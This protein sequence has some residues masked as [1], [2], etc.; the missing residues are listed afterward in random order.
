MALGFLIIP[1]F[2]LTFSVNIH[3]MSSVS[4]YPCYVNQNGNIPSDVILYVDQ[5]YGSSYFVYIGS[6]VDTG[7]YG[8]GVYPF[9]AFPKNSSGSLYA[10]IN[11][12]NTFSL[13]GYNIGYYDAKV[14]SIQK[15]YDGS[16]TAYLIQG[17]Y[18][19][20][21]YQNR[22]S[23]M[24]NSSVDYYTN[25]DLMYNNDHSQ[26]V[27]STGTPPLVLPDGD[28]PTSFDDTGLNLDS[29]LN[30]NNVPSTPSGFSYTA[31]T[32]PTWDS[33]QPVQSVWDYI[34]YGFSCLI[35]LLQGVIN[36]ISNW[37]A[38]IGNILSYVVQKILNFLKAIVQW[39]Y[40][41]FLAWLTPYLKLLVFISKILF[42]EE[43]QTNLFQLISD[44]NDDVSTWFGS[45]WSSS[46]LSSYFTNLVNSYSTIQGYFEDLQSFFSKVALFYTTLVALGSTNG[47][48]ALSTLV[49]NLF[50]PNV[51][52]VALL[53]Y[54]NDA[55]DIISTTTDVITTVPGLFNTLLSLTPTPTFHIP[56][57]VYHGQQIGDFDIDFSWYAPYKVYV[58]IILNGFLIL[59]YIYWL[60]I[61]FGSHLRGHFMEYAPNDPENNQRLFRG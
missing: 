8:G 31:P 20:W 59:G 32:A 4:D 34:V 40:Q 61:T 29:S 45:F 23:S 14:G 33:S 28:D 50:L 44:F 19:Y 25:F 56:S 37:I 47:E 51:S 41:Q 6:S 5:N 48:F 16:W 35:A 13:I 11:S 24:V 12:D 27:I 10:N 58:D 52:D 36:T 53:L 18:T 2:L 17:N 7:Y 9:Y 49:N 39:L 3:A 38:Y 30:A 1:G 42:D 26:K 57:L 21:W 43:T 60:F 46:W 55:F 54:Q 15:N 22:P